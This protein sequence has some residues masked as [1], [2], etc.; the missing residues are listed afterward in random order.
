MLVKTSPEYIIAGAFSA[1]AFLLLS[2]L[3]G[4]LSIPFALLPLFKVA[5]PKGPE[6]LLIP[7]GALSLV[8]SL[9]NGTYAGISYLV[10]CGLC[11]AYI[12]YIVRK[13]PVPQDLQSNP[14]VTTYVFQNMILWM[15]L[16]CVFQLVTLSPQPMY[17]MVQ[18][19]M[20]NINP[21]TDSIKQGQMEKALNLL[22]Q[23]IPYHGGLFASFSLI[24][25]YASFSLMQK[26]LIKRKL[27]PAQEFKLQ[28]LNLSFNLLLT[29]V[30]LLCLWFLLPQSWAITAICGNFALPFL[31]AFFLQGIGIVY[32]FA[33]LRK[34]SQMILVIFYGIMVMFTWL[35]MVMVIALGILEPWLNIKGRLMQGKE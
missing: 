2:P 14:R 15:G 28:D 21:A 22:R 18:Q 33:F 29:T 34:N 11:A 9:L 23:V 24:L 30:G 7:I 32:F 16:V 6:G 3:I 20:A 8:L 27:W 12:S 35:I 17:D 13:A 26:S 5:V 25:T 31:T 10:S 19:M 4:V 1:L